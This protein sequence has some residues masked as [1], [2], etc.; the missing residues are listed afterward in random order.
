MAGE[1]GSGFC[2]IRCSKQW[3]WC[4]SEKVKRGRVRSGLHVSVPGSL[5]IWMVEIPEFSVSR[6]SFPGDVQ[7]GSLRDERSENLSTAL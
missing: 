4:V 6:G 3:C 7:T 2:L 1:I 5:I